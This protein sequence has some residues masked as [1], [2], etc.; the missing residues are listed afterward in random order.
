M[1]VLCDPRLTG[2]PYGRLF[3]DSLPPF[4]R[5]RKVQDVEIF[6]G[7]TPSAEPDT[8]QDWYEAARF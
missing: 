2:K 4:A 8:E 5:T 3:L 6:F 1:L 7:A